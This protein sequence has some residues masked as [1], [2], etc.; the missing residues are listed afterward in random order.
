LAKAR[1]ASESP[2]GQDADAEIDRLVYQLYG[3]RPAQVVQVE[4]QFAE[5]NEGQHT[6][7]G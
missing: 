3:L 6:R 2:S 4:S 7:A 5:L 1:N